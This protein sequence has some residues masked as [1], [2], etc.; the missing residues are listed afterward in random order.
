MA[1]V[2]ADYVTVAELKRFLGITDSGEDEELEAL[3]K[4]ASRV[5]DRIT[6]RRFYTPDDDE[7]RLFDVPDSLTLVLDEDLCSLT[8]IT[9]GNGD[10]VSLSN[11]LQLPANATPKN[12]LKLK[13][14]SGVVWELA[15]SGEEEQVIQITGQWGYSDRPDAGIQRATKALIG[16]ILGRRGHEGVRTKRIGEYL[17]T[18]ERLS[19]AT[20]LPADVQLILGPYIKVPFG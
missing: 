4:E 18:F 7:T 14:T 12:A 9:N 10:A 15:T 3:I 16:G 6:R 1:S 20:D 13:P 5:L 17:V 8:S 19:T 2:H 11:V